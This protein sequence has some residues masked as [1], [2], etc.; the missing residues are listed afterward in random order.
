MLQLLYAP[1]I[2]FGVARIVDRRCRITERNFRINA[3]LHSQLLTECQR[4]APHVISSF[5][6]QKKIIP[7][8]A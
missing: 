8:N 5:S 4:I 7:K 1:I 6:P 3:E 2:G